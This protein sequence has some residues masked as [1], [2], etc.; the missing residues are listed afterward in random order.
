MAAARFGTA[1]LGRRRHASGAAG[2]CG[3]RRGWP[4]GVARMK[5]GGRGFRGAQP[6]GAARLREGAGG[7]VS[8]RVPGEPV[9]APGRVTG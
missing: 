4:G 8:A 5:A 6:G 7:A 3:K 2:V 9:R 1:R